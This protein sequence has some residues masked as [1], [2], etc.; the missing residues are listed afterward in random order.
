MRTSSNY[1]PF[2]I[3]PVVLVISIV[4]YACASSS[5][6]PGAMEQPPQVLPV[7]ALA[8]IPAI[9]F[10][11]YTAR[12]EG[13]RDIEIRSQVDGYLEKIYVDEGQFV[14]KG[15]PLFLVNDRPYRERLNNA[16]AALAA[17]KANQ[18]NAQIN[19][20]KLT[21]LVENN[22]VS[23]VQ[24]KAA[25]STLDA[26]SASVAQAQSS[27]GNAA[28]D[29][30]YTKIKAPA[31][32]YVG[33]IPLKTGSLVGTNVLTMLSEINEV[34]AYFSM[35]ESDFLRFENEFEGKTVATKIKSFPEVELMLADNTIYPSKGKV[36]TV[37]GQFNNTTG[38]ISFRAV[39]DNKSGLLRSGNTG[40]I[41]I[42]RS[43]SQAIVVPQEA[44]FE[45][46]DKVFVFAV[47]DSNKVSSMPVNVSSSTGNYY[48][49]DKGVSEGTRIVYAGA[50][51]LRDGMTIQPQPITMDSLLKVRPM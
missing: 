41:R 32:G 2:L 29:L 39:F 25:K 7:L 49:V 28:I 16:N 36:E 6:N 33:R 19:V 24:L 45:L 21:P 20:N 37:S 8:K 46:Q 26:A 51:R 47:S 23:D 3:A 14:K 40:K 44:T 42:P 22:V 50:D 30:G 18:A 4:I 35:S 13:S 9:T 31:D 11:E 17:A 38:A 5:G 12:L 43:F 34:Y 10:D 27:V 15:Q 48:L 1:P